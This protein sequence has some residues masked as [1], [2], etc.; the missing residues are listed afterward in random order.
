V[1]VLSDAAPSLVINPAL[2]RAALARRFAADGRVQVRDFLTPDSAQRL[3]RLLQQQTPWGLSWQAAEMG[4]HKLPAEQVAG[5]RPEN[6][7][8]M[9][10]RVNAVMAGPGFAFLYAQYL[11]HD[12]AMLGTS[13]SPGHDQLVQDLNDPEFLDFGREVTGRDAI[14]W[15]DSQATLYS[16]GQFL[17]MHQD[18]VAGEKR[19]V[20][21][22]LNL[23]TVDW[24]PDWGGYLNFF[25]GDGDIV[26]GY[27]PRFNSLNMFAVPADHNV[28]YVPGFAPAQGRF[29]ITGWFRAAD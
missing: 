23:C 3:V 10:E 21:Y 15:A 16:R 22:V 20:A 1:I 4:P 2:D 14:A 19:L 11:M 13:K 17:S 12:H 8:A 26:A 7:N 28:S 25:D 27:R 9:L 24:R 29:A 6:I 18:V 5:L